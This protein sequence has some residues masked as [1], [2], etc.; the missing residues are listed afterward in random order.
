[1]RGLDEL[2]SLNIDWA[3]ATFDSV[4]RM[5]PGD[6]RGP[7][8]GSMVHFYLYG[9]SLN[10]K[11]LDLFLDKSERVIDIC[12][13]LL[14]QNEHDA[15]TKFYLGGIYGYRGLA[16]QS[17]GSILKAVR[18]GRKGY[19]YLEDAVREKPDLYDAHMGFGIFR[20]LVAKVPKSMGYLLSLLGFG[21]DLEGGLQS[22]RLAAEKG[23]YT[24]TEAK[25]FLSQFL[26]NEG[27]QDTA[28]QYVRELSATYPTNT[29]FIVL[30]ASWENRLGN[31]DLAFPAALKAMEL[32]RRNTIKYGEDLI[33][34]TLGSIYFTKNMFDSAS[35]YYRRYM[36]MTTNDERTPNITFLRAGEACEIAGDRATALEFYKRMKEPR[37]RFWDTR[38]YRRGQQL[39]QQSLTAADIQLIRAGNESAQKHYDK[40]I[41]LY[42]KAFKEAGSDVDQQLRALYGLQQAQFD[43]ARLDEA[44]E[45]SHTLLSL[46]PHDETWIIP[47]AWYRLGLIYEKQRKIS[48]ARGA[49]GHVS[50][51]DGYEFQAH[52]EEQVKEE[53]S[54]IDAAASK[55]G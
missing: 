53:L 28:V 38:N 1:M 29:L 32:N 11:E 46:T 21:G 34:S 39:I 49:F 22:L 30:F 6:P 50:R 7:F 40:S 36:T 25:L 16:Y 41:D 42:R 54:K 37:D 44:I 17:N 31:V 4:S 26:F 8:F 27:R 23:V 45:T 13:G 20:Y 9:L 2:Y 43:S 3:L 19:L 14:D 47:H 10:Q 5:A 35:A 18:D 12:D 55:G 52:L 33:Y 15:T 51:Y 48:D 24:R